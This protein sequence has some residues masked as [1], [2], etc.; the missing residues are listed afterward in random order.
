[1]RSRFRRGFTLVELL[2]VIGIIAVLIAILLPSLNKARRRARDVQCMAQLRNAGEAVFIYAGANKGKLPQH[3]G[4]GVWLWDVPFG[5]RDA[6][7]KSGGARGTLYCPNF[8]DQ[9][10]DELWNGTFGGGQANYC[11]LGYFWLGARPTAGMVAINTFDAQTNGLRQYLTTLRTPAPDFSDKTMI[12]AQAA[13]RKLPGI[14]PTVPA[15]TELMTD[16]T[17]RNPNSG[18]WT[19]K[20]SWGGMHMTS[21][22]VGKAP[23]GA[24]ILFLDGHVAFRPFKPYTGSKPS[25]YDDV[26]QPRAHLTDVEFWF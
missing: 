2:V 18:V 24:N 12:A 7:V 1:M 22:M 17:L 26:I 6:L 13:L 5:T 15:N 3:V 4:G 19:A 9:N 16:A 10:V 23:E 14:F 25:V 11:V 20:G 8:V 21:H